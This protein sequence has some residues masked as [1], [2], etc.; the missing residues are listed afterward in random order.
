MAIVNI[1]GA[2][3]EEGT[4]IM[5]SEKTYRMVNIGR[6]FPSERD[7]VTGEVPVTPLEIKIWA[8]FRGK[9]D[10]VITRFIVTD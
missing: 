2:R 6:R 8:A 7:G 3:Y 4:K 9:Q 5:G 1:Q 10:V